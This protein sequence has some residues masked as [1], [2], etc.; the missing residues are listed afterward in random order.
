MMS[1]GKSKLMG[2]SEAAS[3]D[4]VERVNEFFNSTEI[5]TDLHWFTYRD[6]L[7]RAFDRGDRRL[8]YVE[9]DNGDIVGALMV[10]C[11]SRVLDEGEAQIRLVAVA[12]DYRGEGI[13][14]LL[15][16]HAEEF[17]LRESQN[18]MIAD[19]VASSPAVGFWKSIGY[20]PI[21]EWDTSGGRSMLTVQ[22][23][24]D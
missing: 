5:K 8:L 12:R 20:D 11:Q 10:W 6:T 9:N 3:L 15:C 21:K 19:V 22:K 13:G 24:L 18:R 17:A 7:V 14:G 1:G 4:D 2:V 23:T 16:E